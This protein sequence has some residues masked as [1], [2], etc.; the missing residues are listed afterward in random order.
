VAKYFFNAK[1]QKGEPYSGTL[2][3]KDESELARTLRQQGYF[4]I[5]ASGQ[6]EKKEKKF[7]LS[8]PFLGGIP[9]QEKINLARNLQVMISAGV[10][11]PKALN[12]LSLQSKS[13]KLK[14]VLVEIS[15]EIMKGKNFSDSL[16]RYPDIFSELFCNMVKVGEESGSLEENLGILSRQMER[17]YELKSKIKGAL[18]YPAVIILAMVGI[19]IMMLVVVVPQL[20]KTFE[21]LETE[22]PL[23]TKAVIFLGTF[24][25]ERWY[26][27][28]LILVIL[29]FLVQ[30]VTKMRTG[31]KTFDKIVLKIPIISPLIRKTNAAY[32][33]R[34]LSSLIASGVSLIR[35]LEIVANTLGNFYFKEAIAQAQEKVQKG[36]KLSQALKPYQNL[37]P[38]SVIQMIE[39]GEETG[40][41]VQILAKLGDFFE[42]EISRATK[43]LAAVI[44]PILMLFIGGVV[45]FFAVSMVQPMYSMLEGIK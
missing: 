32:T 35:S 36:E 42:E 1:S 25:V 15:E 39:V 31:K 10:S 6:K 3:A 34:T 7:E 29:V 5:S 27:A 22:L 2:E 37:Y 45:G 8:I 11:L 12:T 20:A 14:K 26:L 44:E 21:E 17:E 18:M 9:L 43:N 30:A 4:L 33:A 40:E 19:G 28:V 41:T 13:K 23:T 16:S 24:L 38:A